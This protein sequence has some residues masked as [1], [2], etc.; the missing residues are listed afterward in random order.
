MENLLRMLDYFKHF[1]WIG[2]NDMYGNFF[3]PSI[4]LHLNEFFG[5]AIEEYIITEF[6]RLQIEYG[7]IF[8][9]F[10]EN[11]LKTIAK[12]VKKHENVF[13]FK[14]KIYNDKV[15]DKDFCWFYV[16]GDEQKHNSYKFSYKTN[17]IAGLKKFD[18]TLKFV[19]TPDSKTTAR[20]QKRNDYEDS[21]WS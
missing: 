19:L 15:V 11:D 3:I 8:F 17:I 20:T 6:K 4:R 13:T 12:F 7:N 5:T 21:N 14:T 1:L 2:L 16:Y 9:Q 10:Y 18:E